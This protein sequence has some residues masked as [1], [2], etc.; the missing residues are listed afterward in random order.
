MVIIV[1]NSIVTACVQC[2]SN[3]FNRTSIFLTFRRASVRYFHNPWEWDDMSILSI[4]ECPPH[5][6][7]VIHANMGPSAV[8]GPGIPLGGKSVPGPSHI[9]HMEPILTCDTPTD[10]YSRRVV[11]FGVRTHNFHIFTLKTQKNIFGYIECKAY[12]KI[13][14]VQQSCDAEIWRTV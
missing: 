5:L 9:G 13:H 10:E 4:L 8:L 1:T 3:L 6:W 12:N 2:L 14:Y 11:P 7:D